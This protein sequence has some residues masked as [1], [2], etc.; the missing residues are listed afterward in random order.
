MKTA[1]ILDVLRA[2]VDGL[3][4]GTMARVI[5]DCGRMGHCALG[6]LLFDAGVTNARLENWADLKL[7]TPLL[8]HVYGLSDEQS[9]ALMAFSDGCVFVEGAHGSTTLYPNRDHSSPAD[10]RV[11]R[12]DAVM[13][14][15]E[16]E[17][18]SV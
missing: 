12:L 10:E 3:I 15:V 6:A 16:D 17:L 11:E 13:A 8:T 4:D 1:K 2:E 5:E 9:S 18:G 7:W 14:Y